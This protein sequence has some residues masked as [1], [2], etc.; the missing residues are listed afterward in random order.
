[1]DA[2]KGGSGPV[3]LLHCVS[4]YPPEYSTINLRNIPMLQGAFDVPVGF[5]DHTI[6]TS[7]PLVSIALGA[8]VIEKH[9]TL[10]KDAEGW[11]HAISADPDE[12]AEIC[13]EG[14]NAF[15]SLGESRRV[16]SEAEY[17]KRKAFRRCIV[18]RGAKPKGHVLTI[19]DLDFKRPG[20]GI[21]PNEVP[22]VVGRPLARDLPDDAE[23]AWSD[24]S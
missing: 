10:D 5:S 4:I 18:L 7:I 20:T 15:E 13:R 9:F 24:L 16:V 8:C 3:A 6:G 14:Q 1:M 21:H 22:Y 23:L 17:E 19:D 12:M 2:G 11:D